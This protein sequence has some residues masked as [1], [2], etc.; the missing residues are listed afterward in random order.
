MTQRKILVTSALPY[1]NGS[2]HIGHLVEY[3]QTDI[4]V[5]F[6]KMRGHEC[7][8]VCADDTHGTPI[9]IRARQEGI[10]PEALIANSYAEHTQDFADF[11]IAFD[12]YSSTNSEHN[13][14]LCNEISAAMADHTEWLPVEQAYCDTCSMF[15]PDRFVRGT[16]PACGLQDQYGD[17]CDNGHTYQPTELLDPA[18]A[19]C[20][21]APSRKSADHLFFKLEP[22]RAF[23]QEWV[24]GHTQRE[25]ANKLQEWL[26]GEL[27]PWDI[28]RPEPYF[29][30][31]IPGHP[32]Q[33]FYVWVDAPIGYIGATREWAEREGRDYKEFWQSEDAEIYHFIGKDIVYFHTLFWPAMLKGAGYS[34]PSSVFV[35][36]FLTVNGEKMSKSKGTFISARTYLDNLGPM[37]LRYYYAC[38]L[39]GGVEDIDM[40]LDDFIKRVNS[41]LIGKITNVASRGAQMLYKRLDGQLGSIPKNGTQLLRDAQCRAETIAAHYEAREYSKAIVQI[42]EIA[43]SANR[44]FDEQQPWVT[45][46]SDP[47][48]ARGVMTTV[49]NVFRTIA[50][51]LKPVLPGYV[52][53]VEALFIEEPYSWD[54]AQQTLENRAIAA[55][56][57]LA[58]R[59]E[60]KA[61]EAIIEASRQAPLEPEPEPEVKIEP[62][63]DEV[64]FDEFMKVDLRVA[65]IVKAEAI[66]KANKLL[67]LT[68]DLGGE[69]RQII[70]GIKQAYK[71]E[72]LVGRLTV[73]V[74]NLAPRTM[75][76]GVSEGM[77]LAAGE[78]GAELMIL[79]PDDGAKPGQRI[80]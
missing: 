44:Y 3:L 18:C 13:R 35:H 19:T 10:T 45:I 42:R 70:A 49:L 41:D 62:I 24:P 37:Y 57:H 27:R 40:N 63:A 58:S 20:G 59:I 73:V 67:R 68:V 60:H 39:G 23:L 76:F 14:V 11:E 56:T 22:F 65:K 12:N 51:Y 47:E 36:G 78:G 6:Q 15:L 30:F 32:G 66:E 50:I 69:E 7:R 71:P 29:G 52:E 28:S 5:R 25:I 34:T 54:S 9:M 80:S 79:S 8:Y 4:W 48:A 31:E 43:E 46:K 53:K 1:A 75:K 2:I 74:A 61:I 16:C 33:Y 72:D 38:K 26:D 64:S 21:T 77:V 55:Y 17:S